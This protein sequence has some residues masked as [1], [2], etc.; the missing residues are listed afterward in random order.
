VG[1]LEIFFTSNKQNITEK[2]GNNSSTNEQEIH[3]KELKDNTII[4]SKDTN[5][6]NPYDSQLTDNNE[7]NP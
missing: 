3:F 2:L 5:K 6:N 1:A 4:P 7:S